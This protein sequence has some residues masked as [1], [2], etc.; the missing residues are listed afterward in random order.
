MRHFRKGTA[1]LPAIRAVADV[2]VRDG[3]ATGFVIDEKSHHYKFAWTPKGS[4]LHRQISDISYHYMTNAFG[5][6]KDSGLD[7]ALMEI[8]TQSYYE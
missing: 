1:P 3:Y 4:E 7:A 6:M 2:L 5:E 8:L